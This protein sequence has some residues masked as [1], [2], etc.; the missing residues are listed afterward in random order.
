[1][2]LLKQLMCTGWQR[3]LP[4]R[5]LAEAKSLG[6]EFGEAME[7]DK[8]GLEEVLANHPAVEGK[9]QGSPQSCHLVFCRGG[10]GDLG[11]PC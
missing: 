1:M 6:E 3:L 10:R 4:A 8:V 11:P 5:T 7:E 9:L 2:G